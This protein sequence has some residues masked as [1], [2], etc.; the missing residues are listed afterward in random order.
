MQ[1]KYNEL[2]TRMQEIADLGKA[3][4]VLGWDRYT[5]MPPAGAAARSRQS[6][7]LAKLIHEREASD[8]MGELLEE[9]DDWQHTLDY[10]STEAALIRV[11][12]REFTQSRAIPAK[13]VAEMSQAQGDANV[14]WMKARA[15]D[16]F[17]AFLPWIERMFDLAKSMPPASPSS[18]TPTT[19][20][21]MP[22]RKG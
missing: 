12:Q 11:A 15:E 21:W 17:P 2:K 3:A 14:A 6:A 13:L 7:T 19:P 18:L 4:S 10:D 16:D 20:C 9:L 8:E 5:Y 22:T 1:E